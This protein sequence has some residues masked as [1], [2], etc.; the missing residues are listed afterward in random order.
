MLCKYDATLVLEL[1]ADDTPQAAI[2]QIRMKEYCEKL[3]GEHVAHQKRNPF[4]YCN[5]IK[6]GFSMFF[7]FL[8]PL[9]K[10]S[11]ENLTISLRCLQQFFDHTLVLFLHGIIAEPNCKKKWKIEKI[12]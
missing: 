3:K 8:S 11:L 7:S 2:A 5:C 10:F 9:S 4:S 1:K 12:L 6:T